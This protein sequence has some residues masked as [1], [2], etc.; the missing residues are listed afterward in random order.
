[1]EVR[2][3]ISVRGR[4]QLLTV[5][6]R[7]TWS[8]LIRFVMQSVKLLCFAVLA[9]P[10]MAE[11]VGLDGPSLCPVT[12]AAAA[13]QGRDAESFFA[14]L[15]EINGYVHGHPLLRFR[16][17]SAKLSL[18]QRRCVAQLGRLYGRMLKNTR[19]SS[20]DAAR[21]Q[22][23]M[24]G[25]TDGVG[26]SAANAPLGRSRARTVRRV[27]IDA[28]RKELGWSPRVNVE[29][30]LDRDPWWCGREK[31]GTCPLVIRA[32]LP[33]PEPE[34]GNLND[35]RVEIVFLGEALVGVR[36]PFAEFPTEESYPVALRRSAERTRL[37]PAGSAPLQPLRIALEDV[38]TP[39]DGA[40][41]TSTVPLIDPERAA[42]GG[43]LAQRSTTDRKSLATLWTRMTTLQTERLA[44]ER[45]P[46]SGMEQREAQ[47]SGRLRA[48]SVLDDAGDP[49]LLLT[50]ELAT[51]N[52]GPV[53]SDAEEALTEEAQ[54]RLRT[55]LGLGIPN[56]WPMRLRL[57]KFVRSLLA[58]PTL[59][60][61]PRFFDA[62]RDCIAQPLTRGSVEETEGA[63]A[64]IIYHAAIAALPR[65]YDALLGAEHDFNRRIGM[66][67]LR[68]GMRLH[69]RGAQLLFTRDSGS[70]YNLALLGPERI[71]TLYPG[72]LGVDTDTGAVGFSARG[73]VQSVSMDPLVAGQLRARGRWTDGPS[74]APRPLPDGEE[75]AIYNL[76]NAAVMEW[77]L[78]ERES[79]VFNPIPDIS[80]NSRND[81]G[82][83]Y[84]PVP[85]DDPPGQP[86]VTNS[87]DTVFFLSTSGGQNFDQVLNGWRRTVDAGTGGT[88]L[89][90]LA[91]ICAEDTGKVLRCGFLRQ[92]VTATPLVPARVGG[93]DLFAPIDGRLSIY[94]P[95]ALSNRCAAP[96][97]ELA[98]EIV[99]N[100]L[101]SSMRAPAIYQPRDCRLLGVPILEGGDIEWSN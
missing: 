16:T 4:V 13:E 90:P 61:D 65:D 46:V 73:N 27:F 21:A 99:I 53:A 54:V 58:R 30:R 50:L 79:R 94:A 18:D 67:G 66:T 74:F 5:D 100:R 101:S 78:L 76:A 97:G 38:Q 81:L 98:G 11:Q 75:K 68:P 14:A 52:T 41:A 10:A 44:M 25:H 6:E 22:L 45:V 7:P 19:L 43:C 82:K 34:P 88:D 26:P 80:V 59:T 40:G 63:L 51:F 20:K 71:V 91:N 47:V 70:R 29:V 1:M 39:I 15:A 31:L 28:G 83:E 48:L 69:I 8:S 36:V 57:E 96:D 56:Y 24:I 32:G 3:V 85:G 84:A 60:G 89:G 86:A 72:P 92:N 95:R 35:R 37:Y 64:R 2:M 93:S 42:V 33:V 12:Y 9:T 62:I 17:G 77:L 55:A 49:K 23:R 87:R